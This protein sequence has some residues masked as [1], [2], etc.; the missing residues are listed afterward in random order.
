MTRWVIVTSVVLLGSVALPAQ[1]QTLAEAAKREAER[2]AKLQQVPVKTYTSADVEVRPGS[3]P[4][5]G[6]VETIPAE[7]EPAEAKPAVPVAGAKAEGPKVRLK[8]DEDHWRER[9]NVIRDR[10]NKLR[11]D[12]AAIEGRIAELRVELESASGA[13]ATAIS[14]EIQE[15]TKDLTR[16]QRDVRLI[17]GEWAAFEARARD[18]KIPMAWIR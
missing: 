17:D 9:A 13:K 3:G 6:K 5:R 15:A 7:P 11:A 4:G 12:A 2:R 14:A 10:L 16:F 1:G 18:A 8:R